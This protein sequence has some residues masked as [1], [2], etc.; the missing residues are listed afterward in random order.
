MII[1]KMKKIE[2]KNVAKIMLEEF[3]KPPFNEKVSIKDMLESLMFY[4]KNTNIY[5]AVENEIVG[6]IVFQVERWWEGEV[7][8]VQDL[9]VVKK[10]QGKN[11]E[12]NLMN[13]LENYCREYNVVKIHFETNKKSSAVK[14]YEKMGYKIN[15]SRIIMEKNIK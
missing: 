1:R 13:F 12:R 8:I 6:G 3:S 4:Y 5:I 15:K 10:F 7:I 9:F 2:M 11:I 14:F